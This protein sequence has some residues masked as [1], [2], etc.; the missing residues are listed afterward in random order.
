MDMENALAEGVLEV[1]V[2]LGVL[3]VLEPLKNPEHPEH[4]EHL[5]NP[6]NLVYAAL[7]RDRARSDW[8]RAASRRGSTGLRM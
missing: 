5:A 6:E 4:P 7:V 3:E 2:V 8:T 1:L